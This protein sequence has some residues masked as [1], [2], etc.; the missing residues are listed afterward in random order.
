MS[1]EPGTFITESDILELD[2]KRDRMILQEMEI[3]MHREACDFCTWGRGHTREEIL[4]GA[5][6]TI[7]PYRGPRNGPSF[8]AES[9][10][11]GIDVARVIFFA[12]WIWIFV[13]EMSK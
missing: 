13:V 10:G 2:M 11:S 4:A 7:G 9:S 8:S 5:K 1:T 3:S 6:Q 12:F